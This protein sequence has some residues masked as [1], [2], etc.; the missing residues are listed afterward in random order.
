MAMRRTT[1][2][3]LSAAAVGVAAAGGGVAL[4]ARS[5]RN[6]WQRAQ[7]EVRRPPGRGLAG[8]AARHELV[9]LATLAANSHNSQPWRFVAEEARIVVLPD[10]ARRLPAV[11]PDDHHLFAS[12]GAAVEN[13]V[14]AAPLLGLLAAPHFVSDNGGRIDIRL[15]TAA[16]AGSPLAAA[17]ALR[18]CTRA[19]Y[20][21]RPVA[22]ADLAALEAAGSLDGVR[23]ALLTA[24]PALDAIAEQ[25]VAGN[26]VQMRDPA[27]MAELIAWLRFSYSDAVATGD[28]LF[29]ATTANPVLPSW[30]A[31]PMLGLMFTEAAENA[32]YRAHMAGS[33][34]VAVFAAATDTP[35]GWVAAGR[36]YQRF[37]L[38]ATALGL[39]HA[40]VNQPVEVASLRA[41]FAALVGLGGRRPDLVVR[42]GH[43]DALPYALRRPVAA[44]L[45]SGPA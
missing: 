43:G 42:F 36:A 28:G 2:I 7:A 14:L 5:G 38:Q 44:V 1:L 16:E 45:A 12:L 41:G 21:V 37:A 19:A 23:I 11:D 4:A 20:G 24:R 25:V 6:S 13:I 30:L 33:A 8:M 26:T 27:F 35:A 10:L 15:T 31:R 18:Q 9:R 32:K 17:I 40:F 22:A 29:A 3:A 34:G 39:R